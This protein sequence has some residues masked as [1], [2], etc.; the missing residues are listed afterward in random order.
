MNCPKC[1][2]RNAVVMDSRENKK[3][4]YVRRRRKC[5]ECKFLFTTYEG[6]DENFLTLKNIRKEVV[7]IIDL[8][9]DLELKCDMDNV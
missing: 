4:S 9:N 8:L 3:Q 1:E 6:W 5:T 2:E 7:H